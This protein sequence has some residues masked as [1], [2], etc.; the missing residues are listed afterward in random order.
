MRINK[1]QVFTK[2]QMM[3]GWNIFTHS[4]RMVFGNLGPALRIS[5][6][7]YLAYIAVNVYFQL[8]YAADLA[9]LQRNMAM[10]HMPMALPSGLLGMMALNFIVA[11]LTSLWIAVLWHRYVLLTENPDTV[12]PPLLARAIGAYLGKTIQLALMLAIVGLALGMLLG[13]AIGSLL[14]S[15]AASIIPLLLLGVLLYLSYRLGLVMPAV[16]INKPLAFKTSWEKTA[17]AS[18]AIAQL[19][20]IA[21]VFAIIIQIPSNMNPNATSIV[22]LVYTYVV[23]WMAMMVGVSVLTTLYGVY[24]EG[25]EL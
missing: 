8:T 12:I 19:A 22:N 20:V 17:A 6:L 14:G 25:R 3:Q 10:G 5:G 7:L 9:A 21:V 23:G 11:L 16:A 1:G 15:A 4:V 24:I 2:G 18:G 13:V